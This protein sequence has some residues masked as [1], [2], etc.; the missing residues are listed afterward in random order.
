MQTTNPLISSEYQFVDSFTPDTGKK[1]EE[2]HGGV[3]MSEIC[4]SVF[5]YWSIIVFFIPS[6]LVWYINLNKNVFFLSI[7]PSNTCK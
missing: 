4:M 6:I 7:K 2:K 1:R 3:F 5:F